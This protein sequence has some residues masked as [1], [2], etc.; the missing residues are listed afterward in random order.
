MPQ[1]TNDGGSKNTRYIFGG[2]AVT[3]SLNNNTIIMISLTN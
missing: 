2:F 1:P 3:T